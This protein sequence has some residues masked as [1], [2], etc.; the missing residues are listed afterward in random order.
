MDI[1]LE[2]LS[3]RFDQQFVLRKCNFQFKDGQIYGIE[4]ANG[5]GKS[6]LLKIISGYLSLSIGDLKYQLNGKEI[7]RNDIYKYICFSAPYID[8]IEDLDLRE[9]FNYHKKFKPLEVETLKEFREILA[10][11]K[12]KPGKLIRNYSSGMKNRIKLALNILTDS[13]VM[14]LDEPTSFLDSEGVKWFTETLRKYKK[15]KT[16]LIASNDRRDFE[17]CNE[18]IDLGEIQS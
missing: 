12:I 9:I 5:S 15:Q 14:L 6:T 10:Y 2:N 13:D 7:S 3:K 18:V 17:L 1:I 16:I 4:G 8:L 11:D